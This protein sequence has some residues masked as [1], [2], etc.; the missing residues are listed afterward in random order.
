MCNDPVCDVTS[1]ET[2]EIALYGIEQLHFEKQAKIQ[3]MLS[4]TDGFG[5]DCLPP[6][7]PTME[8]CKIRLG[9]KLKVLPKYLVFLFLSR[10]GN[11]QYVEWE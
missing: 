8:Q 5:L 3:R 7:G 9:L 10:K 1:N 2:V 6:A 11:N 4:R